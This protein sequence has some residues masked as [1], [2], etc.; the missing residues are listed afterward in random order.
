[1]TITTR[2]YNPPHPAKLLKE[3]M[4]DN[5]LSTYNL[6]DILGVQRLYISKI[7]HEKQGISVLMALRLE[8]AFGI[9]AVMWINFQR[10]YD[11]WQAREDKSLEKVKVFHLMHGKHHAMA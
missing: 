10:E 3:L 7:L 2:M 9:K 4:E 1:M 6:S 8:K 11:L 5:K